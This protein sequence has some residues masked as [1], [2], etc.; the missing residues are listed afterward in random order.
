M[1]VKKGSVSLRHMSTRRPK[2]WSA[3]LPK[4]WETPNGLEDWES[5]SDSDGASFSTGSECDVAIE[6][7]KLISCNHCA[8]N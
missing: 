6:T 3:K 1:P 2:V 8:C 4:I 5:E 7:G